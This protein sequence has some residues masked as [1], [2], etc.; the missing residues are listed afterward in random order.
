ML[1][2]GDPLIVSTAGSAMERAARLHQTGRYA[3]VDAYSIKVDEEAGDYGEP[4]FHARLG[5]V[6]D[7]EG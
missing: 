4:V 2:P 6:P 7:Y 5:Q 1:V 3:G